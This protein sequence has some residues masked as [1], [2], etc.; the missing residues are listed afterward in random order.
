MNKRIV[1]IDY[2]KVLGMFL[3]IFGHTM[4]KPP[5]QEVKLW[6]YAFHMPLF[7]LM[8]G[9]LHKYTWGGVKTYISY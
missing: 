1:W 6:I 5:G 9:F 4:L 2:A 8:P 3:V 7:F